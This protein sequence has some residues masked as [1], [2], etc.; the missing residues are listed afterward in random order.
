MKKGLAYLL[1]FI[2]CIQSTQSLWI[3]ASFQINR[4]Y[5]ANNLCI[6]RFDK[7][8]VCK[9]QCYLN[10]EL[11]KEQKDN[12]KSLTIIEKEVLYLAPDFAPIQLEQPQMRLL[13]KTFGFYTE[14]TY[15]S[16]QFNFENPPELLS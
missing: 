4:D 8:P 2:F 5:I 9:G 15:A 16:F 7:I 14:G 12:K 1:L 3:I 11:D 10:K 13:E 6:N